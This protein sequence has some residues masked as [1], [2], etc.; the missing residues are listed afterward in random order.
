MSIL[1]FCDLAK[2]S[3]IRGE[4]SD[5]NQQWRV[6][7]FKTF[8]EKLPNYPDEPLRV[9]DS[10]KRLLKVIAHCTSSDNGKLL[11]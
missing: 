11:T 7:T 6:E 10:V 3:N 1:V 9:E 4:A 2:I 8:K 5:K